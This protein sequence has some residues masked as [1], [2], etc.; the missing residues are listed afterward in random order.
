MNVLIDL[1][2]KTYRKHCQAY[3]EDPYWCDKMYKSDCR[4]ETNDISKN[5][6]IL[7]IQN[8]ENIDFLKIHF[9]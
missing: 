1:F 6:K 5:L 9:F 3:V 8:S 2:K 7:K 4:D